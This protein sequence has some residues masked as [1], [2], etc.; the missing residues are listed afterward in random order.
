MTRIACIDTL[1]A[2][3]DHLETAAAPAR[4]ARR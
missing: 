1:T 4:L 2:A 3:V